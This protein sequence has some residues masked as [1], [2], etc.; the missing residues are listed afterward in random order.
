[1][2]GSIPLKGKEEKRKRE[3]KNSN[4]IILLK[5]EIYSVCDSPNQNNTK[6]PKETNKNPFLAKE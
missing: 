3:K 2:L 6:P 4:E 1:M 5:K